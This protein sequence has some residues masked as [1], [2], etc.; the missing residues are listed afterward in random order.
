VVAPLSIVTIAKIAE[1]A[2]DRRNCFPQDPSGF[3]LRISAAGLPPSLT[4]ANRFDLDSLAITNPGNCP[5][6][7]SSS[8]SF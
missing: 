4:P 6:L 3:A 2:K 1:I 5:V 7:D 8:R